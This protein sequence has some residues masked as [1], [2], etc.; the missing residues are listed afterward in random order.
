[1]NGTAT[2]AKKNKDKRASEPPAA[3]PTK[4]TTDSK[5]KENTLVF[6][7][8]ST[9]ASG[10]KWVKE[11]AK[12]GRRAHEADFEIEGETMFGLS[13]MGPARARQRRRTGEDLLRFCVFHCAEKFDHRSDRAGIEV[14][15]RLVKNAGG[16]YVHNRENF[17]MVDHWLSFHYRPA[18]EIDAGYS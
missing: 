4:G 7:S 8:E 5:I 18:M 3:Q 6:N 14:I 9:S 12:L 10:K 15:W 16:I 11:C 17:K 2:S 13:H 1:M